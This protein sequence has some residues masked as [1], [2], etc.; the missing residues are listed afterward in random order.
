VSSKPPSCRL[1][2]RQSAFA[3]QPRTRVSSTMRPL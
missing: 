3:S 2:A 1:S